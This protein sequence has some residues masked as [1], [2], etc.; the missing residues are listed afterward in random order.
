MRTASVIVFLLLIRFANASDTLSRRQVYEFQVGDSF[1]YAY[2]SQQIIPGSYPNT[3][4]SH[5]YRWEVVTDKNVSLNADTFFYTGF[6]S[7]NNSIITDL[8]TAAA[9]YVTYNCDTQYYTFTDTLPGTFLRVNTT[10]V[11]C[12]ESGYTVKYGEG[13]GEIY[14]Y[15]GGNY[16][17]T[18]SIYQIKELVY[19]NKGGQTW[20][21][22]VYNVGITPNYT[23]SG[24]L[25]VCPNPA[26]DIVLVELTAIG[27]QEISVVIIDMQGKVILN[28]KKALVMP[29]DKLKM[30][31]PIHD[32]NNGIYLVSCKTEH[33]TITEKLIVQR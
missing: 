10:F 17:G 6:W 14:Y 4:Q 23:E 20:G 28:P 19:F 2:S 31:I 9:T 11:D 16:D 12:F 22:P 5:Y 15:N 13:L 18:I 25:K 33:G 29:G 27:L 3:A 7:A 32:L 1:L 8:D 30:E 26:S 24:L 21:T